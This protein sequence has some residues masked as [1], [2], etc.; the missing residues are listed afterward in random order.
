[1]LDHLQHGLQHADDGAERLV[2]SFVET[3]LSVEMP[4]ELVRAVYNIND[5]DMSAVRRT[6]IDFARSSK[7]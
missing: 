1:M 6:F 7:T 5:H 3:T 4:E 2:L